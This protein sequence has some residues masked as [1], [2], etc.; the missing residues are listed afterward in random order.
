MEPFETERLLLRPLE[1]GDL[2]D[3]CALYRDPEVMR[4]VTGEPR[5]RRE[6]EAALERHLGDHRRFGY[7][8]CATFL[9]ADGKFIGRCGLIPWRQEGPWQAELAWMFTPAMWGRGLGTEF[10]RGMIAQAWGPLGLDFLMARAYQANAAS[11]AIMRK[12]GMRLAR[13]LP[14]EVY[15]E[16]R[17]P[18]CWDDEESG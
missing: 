3:L 15:Y 18:G 8:L 10:G 13:T 16:V 12:L 7:G 17:K 4:H 2:E 1:A 9:K 5:D 11:V 14:E 6:T